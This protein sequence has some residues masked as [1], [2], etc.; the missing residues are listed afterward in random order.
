MSPDT[1]QRYANTRTTWLMVVSL[2]W[3]TYLFVKWFLQVGV[4]W[5]SC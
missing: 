4:N 5:G 1:L 3:F 2:S